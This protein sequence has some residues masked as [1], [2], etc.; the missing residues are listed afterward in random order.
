MKRIA[1]A[2]AVLAAGLVA[3]APAAQAGA[4]PVIKV[5]APVTLAAAEI[6]VV[7]PETGKAVTNPIKARVTARVFEG[8]L[9]YRIRDQDG[10]EIATG[11]ATAVNDGDESDPFRGTA[12]FDAPF[13]VAEAQPGTFE[14]WEP[15][16]A[17]E[18]PRELF[19][20]R[21]PVILTP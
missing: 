21:V 9:F 7:N 14:V 2:L 18:G 15:N 20:V 8:T 5:A 3:A 4:T 1:I 10:N 16:M 17:D 12:S 19:L 6:V 13:T 11:R